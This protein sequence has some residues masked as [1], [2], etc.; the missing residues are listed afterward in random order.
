M[1]SACVRWKG[2]KKPFFVSDKGLKVNSKTY[3]NTWKKRLL[4]E[5]NRIINNST[6]IFI[7]DSA[8]SHHPNIIQDFLKEK[9]CKRFFKIYYYTVYN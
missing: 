4:R 6:W 3:K 7:Q 5:V 1:V 8:P 2:A 9:L